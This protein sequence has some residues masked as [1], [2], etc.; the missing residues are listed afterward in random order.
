MLGE[1]LQADLTEFFEVSQDMLCILDR[2]G[3]LQRVNPSWERVLGYSIFELQAQ[4]FFHF[5]HPD[6]R[7]ASLAAFEARHAEGKRPSSGRFDN[8]YKKK[9]GTY[10]WISW[11]DG[12]PIGDDLMLLRASP[13]DREREVERSLGMVKKLNEAMLVALPDLMFRVSRD[14]TYLEV[15][16]PRP[17]ELALPAD[18]I[19]GMTIA[20]TPLPD[21]VKRASLRAIENT[22]DEQRLEIMEYSLQ[23]PQGEKYFEA[24]IA[25]GL[26]GEAVLIV[27]DISERK[28]AE[29]ELISA[30]EQALAAASAKAN[31]LANMSHEIRTP[32]NAIMGMNDLLL[33]TPLSPEQRDY[34][35][36]VQRSGDALLNIINDILDLSKIEAGQLKVEWIPFSLHQLLHDCRIMIEATAREKGIE[37]I[38]EVDPCLPD[39]VT[40]DPTRIRQ[41][42][43]NLLS[44]AVKFTEQGEV[45]LSVKQRPDHLVHFSVADTGIGMSPAQLL[46]IFE[47][48][49]QADTSMTRRFGGTGLGLSISRALVDTMGGEIT[50][51][52]K[53][54][55]GSTFEFFLPLKA[56]ADATL[57]PE[58]SIRAPE[59]LRLR[60]LVAEDN[61]VNRRLA[62]KL[63]EKLGC[64][65]IAVENGLQAVRSLEREHFDLVLM[66]CQMPE[67][68]GYEA[69]RAI[70]ELEGDRASTPV[71]ALTAHAMSGDRQ[72]CIDAGMDDYLTK[73]VKRAALAR[74]LAR[75]A[76]KN[77]SSGSDCA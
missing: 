56:K 53:L 67:M 26:P 38:T 18:H 28:L 21:E 68:D 65:G 31:F 16:A 71:V 2:E 76:N 51:T 35:E 52:S 23:L 60:V 9:D 4:P 50:V 64:E 42:L 7:Q 43:L 41:T 62:L 44:N 33:D 59:P 45:T 12:V 72:R 77:S 49:N 61:G 73:P 69:T 30:Q 32:M 57:N 14:G 6:D 75:W 5:V 19:V 46:S 63:L 24:R 25:P 15:H 70:R 1:G 11:R 58:G 39:I 10:T 48:F 8:R 40:G 66:D 55:V 37:L 34:V 54:A 3:Y 22:I 27:R 17:E 13:I 29:L 74:A 47:P 36:V 20:D